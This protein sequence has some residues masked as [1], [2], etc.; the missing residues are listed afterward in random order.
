MKLILHIGNHKTGTT[1]IQSSLKRNRVKLMKRYGILYPDSFRI[2]GAHH[3]LP[4]TILG[5]DSI[6]GV[7]IKKPLEQ[8][9]GSF[10]KEL[11]SKN[12]DT[13]VLGSEEFFRF[14]KE[15]MSGLKE[16]FSL[17]DKVVIAVYLRNQF[18]HIESSYRFSVLWE[19][20]H[21][22]LNFSDYLTRNLSSDYHCY[23]IRLKEW[24]DYFPS[25]KMKVFDFGTEAE[26]G[27]LRGFYRKL[28][29]IEFDTEESKEN[30]SLNRVSTILLRHINTLNI[31]IEC[32][33]ESV[34]ILKEFDEKY[35]L[36]KRQ[37][38]YTQ[39]MHRIVSERFRD[40]NEALKRAFGIDLNRY[41]ESVDT[42]T[43]TGEEL[44]SLE[45]EAV[46]VFLRNS[47]SKCRNA[48]L[49]HPTLQG[50]IENFSIKS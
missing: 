50:D 36:L 11:K 6:L 17:F 21:L 42:E 5:E 14:S 39:D 27:L 29:N 46:T 48:L 32:R 19:D 34:S 26:S 20:S 37:R 38:L 40:S 28:L 44:R 31:D 9:I 23:D 10:S 2:A 30:S 47:V 22:E 15:D 16:L 18:D 33:R 4:A 41:I 13:V 25:I 43:L 24:H 49:S 45:R 1:T 12:P 3:I 7:E 8:I 35:P